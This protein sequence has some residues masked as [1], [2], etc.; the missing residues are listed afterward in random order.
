MINGNV[1]PLAS[2]DKSISTS[3]NPLYRQFVCASWKENKWTYDKTKATKL[4]KELNVEFNN[5]SFEDFVTAV[6][7]SVLTK[8]AVLDDKKAQDEALTPAE[9]KA[10]H[11]KRIES[12]LTAQLKN[13]S[14]LEL[15]TIIGRLGVNQSKAD[16]KS[17][18]LPTA[19]A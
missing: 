5:C 6:E 2:A 18:D 7:S 19:N 11:L 10:N 3:L 15:K 9:I 17:I 12:Y 8:Q 13:V 14:Q 16:Q 1:S 4:L